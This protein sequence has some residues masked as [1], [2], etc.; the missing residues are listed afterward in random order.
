MD[1]PATLSL[2]G[3]E[4]DISIAFLVSKLYEGRSFIALG[5]SPGWIDTMVDRPH[6]TL[7][8]LA[9][10]FF[11]EVHVLPEIKSDA[12]FLYGQALAELRNE[13]SVASHRLDSKTTV[14]VTMLCMYEVRP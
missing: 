10:L 14:S 5:T 9:A 1:L 4:N 7:D 2:K 13:L 3:F 11:G 6:K 12:A 8:A